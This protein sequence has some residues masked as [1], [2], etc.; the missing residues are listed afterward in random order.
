MVLVG[1]ELTKTRKEGKQ[2]GD[3]VVLLL[4]KVYLH[5]SFSRNTKSKSDKLPSGVSAVLQHVRL[6]YLRDRPFGHIGLNFSG[7]Q[8]INVQCDGIILTYQKT[9]K[10]LILIEDK[11]VL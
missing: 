7:L 3:T 1:L 9:N 5:I 2:H 10:H 6:C 11:C 4:H 8:N